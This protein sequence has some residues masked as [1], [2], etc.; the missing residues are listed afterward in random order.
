MPWAFVGDYI[1][2][3]Q[4]RFTSK[5]LERVGGG[6]RQLRCLHMALTARPRRNCSVG[7]FVMDVD[8]VRDLDWG[9]RIGPITSLRAPG[10]QLAT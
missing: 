3:P 4:I 7:G 1:M 6:I 9:P 2:A 8:Q 10:Q 5:F